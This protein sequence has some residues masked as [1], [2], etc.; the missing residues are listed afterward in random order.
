M[1]CTHTVHDNQQMLQETTANNWQWLKSSFWHCLIFAVCIVN[2]EDG[3][4]S[5]FVVDS[6]CCSAANTQ[7][8][9]P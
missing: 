3:Q 5:V 8:P 7:K 9:T 1:H 6:F 2:G 4:V